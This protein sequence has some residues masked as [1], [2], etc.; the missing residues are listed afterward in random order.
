MPFSI[1]STMQTLKGFPYLMI[2]SKPYETAAGTE[3][4]LRKGRN[5]QNAVYRA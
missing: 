4:F 2:P 3:S 1:Y 5:R